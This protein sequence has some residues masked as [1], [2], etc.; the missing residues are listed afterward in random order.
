MGYMVEALG[1]LNQDGYVDVGTT[2]SF[3]G[4]D[5]EVRILSGKDGHYLWTLSDP[6]QFFSGGFGFSL[7]SYDR[8]GDGIPEIFVGEPI[9]STSGSIHG[10]LSTLIFIACLVNCWQA[11]PAFCD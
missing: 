3:F 1:D 8:T 7:A 9:G 2:L 5:Q 10:F 6:T 11:A 4:G